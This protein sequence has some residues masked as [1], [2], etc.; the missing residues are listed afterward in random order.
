[1][2]WCWN[3]ASDCERDI[4][5]DVFDGDHTGRPTCDGELSHAE[6]QFRCQPRLQFRRQARKLG[7]NGHILDVSWFRYPCEY[8][9]HSTPQCDV[10]EFP[11]G[12]LAQPAWVMGSPGALTTGTVVIFRAWW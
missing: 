11:K 5:G 3:V 9:C 8:R 6:L 1:M 2:P 7:G 4:A 10:V 12:R